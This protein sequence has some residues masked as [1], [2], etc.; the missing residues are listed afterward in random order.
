MAKRT[1]VPALP[2]DKLAATMRKLRGLPVS[3]RAKTALAQILIEAALPDRHDPDRLAADQADHIR[4]TSQLMTERAMATV[5]R[6]GKALLTEIST[7]EW[8][9][10]VAD[11]DVA[12]AEES[13]S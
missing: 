9:R 6:A 4:T 13:A 8:E 2:P 5:K 12:G 11:A 1:H 3:K 10:L 7:E